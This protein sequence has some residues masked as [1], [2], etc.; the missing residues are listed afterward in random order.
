[1][2]EQVAEVQTN[3]EG[4]N[5]VRTDDVNARLLKES[6]DNKRKAKELAVQLAE[7]ENFKKA[8]LEEEGNYKS[9]LEQAN[10]KLKAHEEES[11]SLKQKTLK[12]NIVS[13]IS[14]YA[15]DAV[16]LEDLMNQPKFKS[17]IEEGIDEDSLSLSQEAAEKYVKA[18]YEA[19]PHLR[20]QSAPVGTHKGGK[21][22]YTAKE[23]PVTDLS[24]MSREELQK[25][26]LSLAEKGLLK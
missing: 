22:S 18:V 17:I 24:S 26:I 14:R 21:P 2:S 25:H 10:A 16:D 8:K 1:M 20:K 15:T 11:K 9:L 13:Q 3:D 4:Q 5:S 7:L 6:Q 19:K 12:G 23:V